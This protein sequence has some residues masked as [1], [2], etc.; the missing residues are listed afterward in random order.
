MRYAIFHYCFNHLKLTYLSRIGSLG[1]IFSSNIHETIIDS[2][3][4][5][6]MGW[7]CCVLKII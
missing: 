1:T 2:M 3:F 7:L 6:G 5:F 4:D